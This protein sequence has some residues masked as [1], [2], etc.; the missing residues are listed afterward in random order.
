V[1][2]TNEREQAE[3]RERSSSRRYTAHS[4][5]I[6]HYFTKGEVNFSCR[7]TIA[8]RAVAALVFLLSACLVQ[9]RRVDLLSAFGAVDGQPQREEKRL[10]FVGEDGQIVDDTGENAKRVVDEN[11]SHFVQASSSIRKR[12]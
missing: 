3:A 2:D 12:T 10:I 11:Y 5:G 9:S 4:R 6:P 1:R 7:R 8:M